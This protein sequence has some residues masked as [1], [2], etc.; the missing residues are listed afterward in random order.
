VVDPFPGPE[1]AFIVVAG[2]FQAADHI[3]TVRAFLNRSQQIHE[4]HFAGA[5][6]PDDLDVSRVFE[7]HGTCQVRSGIASVFTAK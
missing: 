3:D 6:H 1:V 7:S 2:P 4:I 5:R